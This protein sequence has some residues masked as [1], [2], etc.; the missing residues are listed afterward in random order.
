MKRV[1]CL[2]LVGAFISGCTTSISPE[3]LK[4]L[5]EIEF[6]ARKM[7]PQTDVGLL[8]IKEWDRPNSGLRATLEINNDTAMS[9]GL[10][11]KFYVFC[12]PPGGYS[13]LFKGDMFLPNR[14]EYLQVEAGSIHI[15]EF[16]QILG[17]FLFIPLWGAKLETVSIADAKPQIELLRVGQDSTYQNSQ[18]RCK[19]LEA[20]R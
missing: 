18:Y 11:K 16:N 3:T 8:Y 12:L 15:R 17:G 6:N 9:G 19:S 5:Y 2:L 14:Y 10:Y 4:N 13:L 20:D 7:Q 1:L